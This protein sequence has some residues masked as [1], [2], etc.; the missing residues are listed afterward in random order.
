M[1][2]TWCVGY[3]D[4]VI[5]NIAATSVNAYEM[6]AAAVLPS[7]GFIFLA[8]VLV[9]LSFCQNRINAR[10]S[11]NPVKNLLYLD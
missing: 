8:I 11:I 7:I 10:Y 3:E 9:P 2:Y 6:Y 1:V 4:G 5:G